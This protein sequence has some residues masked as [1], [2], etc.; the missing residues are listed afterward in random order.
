MIRTNPNDSE[1]E[2]LE[3][4]SLNVS[5]IVLRTSAIGSLDSTNTFTLS[6]SINDTESTGNPDD[7]T[8]IEFTTLNGTR[9]V[10]T[11]GNEI[12]SADAYNYSFQQIPGWLAH[13]SE[14]MELGE[15][16]G[17]DG[18]VATV[19]FSGDPAIITRGNSVSG[20]GTPNWS[21][22]TTSTFSRSTPTYSIDLGT[23]FTTISGSFS[24]NLNA[25]QA[26]SQMR[27]A[28]LAAHPALSIT[29]PTSN[30]MDITYDRFGP[31]LSLI[32]I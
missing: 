14:S 11:R 7:V 24:E 27:T 30:D 22:A 29:T 13:I 9:W 16:R 1:I 23:P 25:T 18:Q 5:G 12:S 17:P 31:F 32:H 20:S 8:Q 21:F 6:I 19:T 2:L 4:V 10:I 15:L 26:L 3:G 28:L